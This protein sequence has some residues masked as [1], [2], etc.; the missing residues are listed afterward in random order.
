MKELQPEW[1]NIPWRILEALVSKMAG[2]TRGLQSDS[3]N[4]ALF[5]DLYLQLQIIYSRSMTEHPEASF[6]CLFVCF[7]IP[8]KI[9]EVFSQY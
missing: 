2:R 7:Y 1:T 9:K 3:D 5:T 4:R 8:V 6:V